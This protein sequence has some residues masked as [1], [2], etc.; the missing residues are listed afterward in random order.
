MLKEINLKNYRC[1]F[2]HTVEFK[3]L[4]I[5][6]GKNNAGKST[7]IEALR[8]LH[9]ITSKY[10]NLVFQSPPEWLDLP[11]YYKGVMPSL[12]QVDISYENI[13]HFYGNPPAIISAIFEGGFKVE[14]Y[15][16]GEKKVFGLLLDTT[17]ELIKTKADAR[18]INFPEINILPQITPL[19]V[20]ELILNHEYVKANLFSYKN[21]QHFRNQINIFYE[22]FFNDFKDIAE[23]TWTG[24]QIKEFLGKGQFSGTPLKLN[25]RDNEF[26]AEIGWMGHGL[27]MWLQ[28]IW[29]LA[30]SSYNSTIILDEPDVYLH[31]DLQRKLIRYIKHKY[32]QVIIATHSVEIITEVEPE[33]ILIIDRKAPKSVYASK[34]P[35]VQEVISNIGSIQNIEVTRLFTAKKI[36]IVEGK[37]IDILKRLQDTLFPNSNEPFDL[38]PSISIGGWGGWNYA[39]GSNM[40]LKNTGGKSIKV[41]C[42]FDRDYHNSEEIQERYREA[43]KS[44]IILHIWLKKEIENYLIVPEAV[45]R[46]INKESNTCISDSNV[47]DIIDAIYE[48]LK[49]DVISKFADGIQIKYI[50]EKKGKSVSVIYDEASKFVESN[51]N[52]KSDMVSGKE[53]ISRL[54]QYL[55]REFNLSFSVK[56]LAKEI[57]KHEI[58]QEVQRLISAIE[59][60]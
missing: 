25:V 12:K 6:V 9:L 39:I 40:L 23:S 57:Q 1:Y 44:N 59:K 60:N 19:S 27:Q 58:E 3:N 50:R 53:V 4:T 46:I 13:F 36:I 28:T 18:K 16:G 38:I 2:D 35:V 20:D 31:A 26:V 55:M 54:N 37:D 14:V 43:E 22:R 33:D 8:L 5:V 7:L 24:L 51:W 47:K 49:Q 42:I 29:F 34:F 45:A 17:G 41:Y 11:N 52:N 21:S 32:K 48:E 56:K 30:R 10:Q 15:I